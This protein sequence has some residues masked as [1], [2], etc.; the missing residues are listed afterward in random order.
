MD[1]KRLEEKDALIKSLREAA[2]ASKRGGEGRERGLG[3]GTKRRR[4]DICV[5]ECLYGFARVVYD[6]M[7]Q[8]AKLEISKLCSD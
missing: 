1:E 7:S 5:Q 6:W 8:Y 2:K 4:Y 3:E